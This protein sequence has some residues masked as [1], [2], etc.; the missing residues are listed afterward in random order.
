MSKYIVNLAPLSSDYGAPMTQPKRSKI[1]VGLERQSCKY[2]TSKFRSW[3]ADDAAE[4]LENYLWTC[5]YFRSVSIPMLS[6]TTRSTTRDAFTKC[7]TKRLR[8]LHILHGKFRSTIPICI[9]TVSNLNA[10]FI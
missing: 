9:A 8:S 10:K 7:T 6:L 3:R 2:G 4:P 1:T 5:T